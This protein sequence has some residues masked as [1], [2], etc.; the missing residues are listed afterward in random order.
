VCVFKI[1]TYKQAFLTSIKWKVQCLNP[2][3]T[4]ILSAPDSRGT[5]RSRQKRRIPSLSGWLIST[6]LVITI[7]Q[8]NNQALYVISLNSSSL[9]RHT[10]CV[11]ASSDGVVSKLTI[12]VLIKLRVPIRQLCQCVGTFRPT[13]IVC[14]CLS[15]WTTTHSSKC[16]F[17][18]WKFKPVCLITG[19]GVTNGLSSL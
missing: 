9:S 14:C 6:L 1:K 5:S 18:V 19:Q 16:F 11:C 8:V 13:H 4:T 15:V 12:R 3:H 2:K 10:R 7:M 17:T